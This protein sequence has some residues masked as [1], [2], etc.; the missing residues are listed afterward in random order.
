MNA[1]VRRREP[2][3]RPDAILDAALEVFSEMG[4]DRASVEVIATRAK[5]SKG[6][7]Y[8]YFTSKKAMIEALVEQSSAQIADAAAALS[9]KAIDQDPIM[10]LRAV[11]RLLFKTISDPDIS[12]ATRIVLAEGA[13]FPDL[14]EHYRARVIN[15]GHATLEQLVSRGIKAGKLRDID[16]DVVNRAL[17]GP[18]VTQLMMSTM[19]RAPGDKDIDPDAMAEACFDLILNGLKARD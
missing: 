1:H 13:R 9:R 8:L 18:A 19:F 15:T 2:D 7:V 6:T 16:L 10:A 11:F 14:A 5:V 4:Y 17:I 12:A 3:K